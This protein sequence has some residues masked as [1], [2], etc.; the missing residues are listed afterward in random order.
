MK[1]GLKNMIWD[2][3]R[4]F[5]R[6]EAWGNPDKINGFLLILLD[7]IRH[8]ASVINPDAY[9]VIHCGYELT[10][11]TENSQHY[12]GSAADFHIVGLSL[13]KAYVLIVE[14]IKDIQVS[15]KVGLGVYLGWNSP[16]FHLD[17]RGSKARWSIRNGEE[18]AIEKAF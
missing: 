2:K 10:G 13:F 1:S 15:D 3:L 4:Y 17:V 11:H 5:K 7:E 18:M 14:T 8:R 9:I 12:K 16:G 6:S